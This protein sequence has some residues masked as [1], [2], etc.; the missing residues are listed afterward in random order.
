M[1][2]VCLQ[3]LQEASDALGTEVTGLCSEVSEHYEHGTPRDVAA[4]VGRLITL[5]EQ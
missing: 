1:C 5:S 2:A 4:K 3:A